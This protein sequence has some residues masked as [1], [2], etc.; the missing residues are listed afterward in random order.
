M[1]WPAWVEQK[2]QRYPPPTTGKVVIEVEFYQT[3]ITNCLI[4]SGEREKPPKCARE[5]L[6]D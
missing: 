1:I 4:L 5:S 3:G 2:I 6:I